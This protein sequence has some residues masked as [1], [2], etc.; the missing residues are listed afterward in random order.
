MQITY[1]KGKLNLAEFFRAVTLRHIKVSMGAIP[2]VALR[3]FFFGGVYNPKRYKP[4]YNI[5]RKDT[6]RDNAYNAMVRY[7]LDMYSLI[8]DIYGMLDLL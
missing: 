3:G 8:I 6:N 2:F 7:L 5:P 1:S 4:E